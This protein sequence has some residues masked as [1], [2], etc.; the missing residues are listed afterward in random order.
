MHMNMEIKNL[1]FGY[2][3]DRLILQDISLS[4]PQGEFIGILGP[5][6]TGKTTLIRCLDGLLKPH[7]GDVLLD[8]TSIADISREELAKHIAYVPQFSRDEFSL[9]VM[10]TVLMG[11]LPYVRFSYSEKDMDL[12]ADVLKQMN[13]TDLAHCSLHAMSG[14]ERQRAYI[15]RALAQETE[16]IILDEPTSSLDLHNQLLIMRTIEK[17]SREK[18]VT[19]LMTIHDLNLASLFCKKI[20]MLQDARIFAFGE[21]HDVL[22]EENVRQIYQVNTIVSETDGYKYV[23]LLKE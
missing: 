13:L 7:A 10:D 20:L 21:T 23:R 11:R 3:H 17:I 22:T 9:T 8:G 18:K 16:I 4:I 2:A 12:A 14:G 5:N 6:G 19:I 1:S 15:A